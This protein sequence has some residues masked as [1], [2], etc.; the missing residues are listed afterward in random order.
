[1]RLAIK[2]F[3]KL[4]VRPTVVITTISRNGIP[5]AAPFSYTSPV[6]SKPP[7]FG[8]A[9]GIKHDT[10]RNVMENGE[11]V[12]NFVGE[13]FG[14]LMNILERDFPYEV[15]EIE[16]AALTAEKS[17]VV[18][19]PRIK[20]AYAWLECRMEDHLGTWIV[21]QVLEVGTKNSYFEE[22]IDVE[23][24][25]PLNHIY[26]EYFVTEMKVRKFKRA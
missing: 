25:K 4:C 2:E 8:F 7:R 3:D 15:S 24:A 11:F 5:N 20:E 16:K 6:S 14:P 21:G 9:C 13:E 1:M 19:P 17:K 18:R 22:V 12:V 23:K 10:W 26:G